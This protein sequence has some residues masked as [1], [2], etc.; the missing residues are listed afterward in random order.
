[1]RQGD[2]VA[3]KKLEL[4]I[5]ALQ[6][7]VKWIKSLMFVTAGSSITAVITTFAELIIRK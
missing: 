7:D 6:Q 4:V 3:T 2:K 5:A 1:M